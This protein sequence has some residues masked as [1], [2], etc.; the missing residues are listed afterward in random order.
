MES[1]KRSIAKSITWRIGG[2]CVTTAIAFIVTGKI[3]TA[4]AIGAFDTL[5]K[6]GAYYAHERMWEKINFGR[7]KSP[8][9]QI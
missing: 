4:A 7:K 9:Y 6:L 8:D 3:E 1:H 2:V 5:F